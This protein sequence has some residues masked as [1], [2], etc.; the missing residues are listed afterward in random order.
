MSKRCEPGG[1]HRAALSEGASACETPTVTSSLARRI[2]DARV[3]GSPRQ[4]FEWLFKAN[5]PAQGGSFYL[6]SKVYRAKEKFDA[7]YGKSAGASTKA[8]PPPS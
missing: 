4:N 6:Q 5:D 3:P 8:N 7:E 2:A 1:G